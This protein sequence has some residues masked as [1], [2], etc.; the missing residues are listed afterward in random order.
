M[1]PANDFICLGFLCFKMVMATLTPHWEC[2]IKAVMLQTAIKPA[3]SWFMLQ[4][5]GFLT[6]SHLPPGWCPSPLNR[7][8]RL[9]MEHQACWYLTQ[10]TGISKLCCAAMKSAPLGRPLSSSCFQHFVKLTAFYYLL[11]VK[12]RATQYCWKNT[13]GMDLLKTFQY[14]NELLRE[15]NT[16]WTSMNVCV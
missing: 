13:L 8:A 10:Y 6:L 12:D 9:D 4:L 2:T 14:A 16:P 15:H 1:L 5:A 3:W 11:M 7:S